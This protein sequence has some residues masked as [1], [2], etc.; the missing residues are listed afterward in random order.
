[1]KK[2]WFH[3]LYNN[4]YSKVIFESSND[5]KPTV[6]IKLTTIDKT[7]LI[8]YLSDFDNNMLFLTF[9]N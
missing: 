2:E 1:M 4:K 8:T 7:K 5:E 6:K 9:M 3:E